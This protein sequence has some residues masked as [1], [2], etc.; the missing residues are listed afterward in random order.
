MRTT[1][2]QV[3]TAKATTLLSQALARALDFRMSPIGVEAAALERRVA[4]ELQI[5]AETGFRTTKLT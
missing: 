3:F 1:V 2:E 5:V 4:A